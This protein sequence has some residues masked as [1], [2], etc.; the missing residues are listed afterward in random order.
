MPIPLAPDPIRVQSCVW[1]LFIT[2]RNCMTV[3]SI[4]PSI[5]LIIKLKL[6][7][8]KSALSSKIEIFSSTETEVPN[9]QKFESLEKCLII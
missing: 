8:L 5:N 1:S 9:H 3:A 7:I 2:N 6:L 4:I